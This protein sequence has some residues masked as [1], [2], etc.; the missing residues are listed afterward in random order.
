MGPRDE[1]TPQLLVFVNRAFLLVTFEKFPAL[2]FVTH[3]SNPLLAKRL[4]CEKLSEWLAQGTNP[5]RE[6]GPRCPAI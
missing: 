3:V 6:A 1:P 2:D 5:L 4:H